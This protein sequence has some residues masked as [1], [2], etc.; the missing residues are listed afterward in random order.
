MVFEEAGRREH[1]EPLF[2]GIHN[3]RKR[4]NQTFGDMPFMAVH[5]VVED[6]FADTE[7]L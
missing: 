2:F 5:Y 1:L 4:N 7:F 6:D 3:D